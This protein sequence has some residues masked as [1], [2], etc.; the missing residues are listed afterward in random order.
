MGATPAIK[1]AAV[2]SLTVPELVA[3]A[4]D[5]LGGDALWKA[6]QEHGESVL[7]FVTR[8]SNMAKDYAN[9]PKEKVED[10][11]KDEPKLSKAEAIIS[12]IIQVQAS[13]LQFPLAAANAVILLALVL[14]IIW[15]L[16]RLVDIRKEL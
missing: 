15:A 12:K 8:F 5:S 2:A 4:P 11:P 7:A 16:T 13:Y 3:F 6:T 10:K 1:V 9:K 14:M